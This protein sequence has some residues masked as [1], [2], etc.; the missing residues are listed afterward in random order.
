[1]KNIQEM[2]HTVHVS[3]GY[4]CSTRVE[5]LLCPPTILVVSIVTVTS[6]GLSC[7][8][9]FFVPT[10]FPNCCCC[11][12]FILI[13]SI[14]HWT[15]LD[16]LVLALRRFEA[17]FISGISF[18]DGQIRKWLVVVGVTR[19]KGSCAGGT[20]SSRSRH[21]SGGAVCGVNLI[22]QVMILLD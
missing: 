4:G 13:S 16:S 6:C 21:Y 19:L 1:M 17:Q 12:P 10:R 15:G 18:L 9:T 5:Q 2:L 7:C 22:P 14:I 20:S 11:C 3:A 8:L